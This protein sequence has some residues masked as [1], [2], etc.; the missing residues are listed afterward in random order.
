MSRNLHLVPY[1]PSWP[2]RFEREAARLRKALGQWITAIEHVGSTAVP[3]LLAKPVIDIAVA[4]ESEA[5][6]DAC[7]APA[8]A[9]GYEYRGLHGEDPRRRY[10]VLNDAGHRIAQLHLYILP[11]CAWTEL[12]TFR[13]ALRTQPQLAADYSREKR[14]VAEAV[15]WDKAAYSLAKGPFI[16][17]ALARLEA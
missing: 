6:A 15:E 11:A 3:G 9:L 5:D 8:A 10:Y 12:L 4:V 16:S 17:A 2:E 7:V 1:D 14:R 13:D